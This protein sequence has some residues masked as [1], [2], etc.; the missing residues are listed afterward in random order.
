MSVPV[1]PPKLLVEVVSDDAVRRA[2]LEEILRDEGL[3]PQ[4][5]PVQAYDGREQPQLIV[6]VGRLFDAPGRSLV[7]SLRSEAPPATRVVV[8]T[9]HVGR[10]ELRRAIDEGLDGLVWESDIGLS[11]APTVRAVLAGQLVIPRELRRRLETPNLSTREKQVLS[12]VIMG[13]SNG[14]IAG[15][16]FIAQT[17]VKTHLGSA[18]RKL[19]VSSRAEAA[20]LITDPEEGLGTGILRITDIGTLDADRAAQSLAGDSAGAPPGDEA[21]G[22]MA[23]QPYDTP[24][25]GSRES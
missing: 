11:L 22:K 4:Q 3:S 21:T 24:D 9:D 20:H 12:L 19:G 16:L 7:G 17:T 13:L 15:R 6:A 18:F 5:Q 14:E 8:C 23:D 10:R 25:V 2:R 1:E